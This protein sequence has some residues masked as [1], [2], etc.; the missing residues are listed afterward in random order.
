MDIGSIPLSN[1]KTRFTVWA[2][3]KQKMILH[4]LDP[5]DNKMQMEKD[6]FGCFHIEAS[7]EAGCRYF[8]IPEGI[9]DLPD[10]A[11]RFQPEGV[12]GPSQVTEHHY[13]WNEGN[14]RGIPFDELIL[15]ELHTGTFTE[16]GTFEAAIEKLDHLLRTGVNAI[17]IMPVAQFPGK[18][19]WGYD[20]VFP[21]AVQNSYG[22]PMGLKKL[23]DA[24]HQRGIAVFL[25][26][27]H[28]HLGP[29]GNYLEQFGPYFT[30]HYKTPWGKAI[31]FD[32]PW[33]DGVRDFF[34][35]N[36]L[37]WFEHFHL[38]GLRFD[39]IH[40]VYDVGAVHIWQLMHQKI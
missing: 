18:R 6:G 36:A 12:H 32:G 39:A 40:Q 7:V 27:V 5:V 26:V 16:E 35:E 37:Y 30:D 29:E 11:S 2:P 38:D 23:V 10:P 28:N 24:C 25:D 22:G 9:K 1:G 15:Y 34:S 3:L 4:I 31:N 17:Q 20:G 13:Q 21:Y 19:N 14:W 8:F 33:S